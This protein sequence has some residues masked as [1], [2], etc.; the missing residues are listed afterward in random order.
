MED[1]FFKTKN[2]FFSTAVVFVVGYP[3][4]NPREFRGLSE[5]FGVGPKEVQVVEKNHFEILASWTPIIYG[6][7][8]GIAMTGDGHERILKI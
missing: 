2:P 5:V 3:I 1:V 8:K 4:P 7:P 6:G